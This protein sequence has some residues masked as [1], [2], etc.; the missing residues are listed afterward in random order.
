MTDAH[1]IA[2]GL[3]ELD[4]YLAAIGTCGDGGC[5]VLKPKGMHTNGGCRCSRS[6]FTMQRL[7]YGHRRFVDRVRA[8]LG[9]AEVMDIPD[10]WITHDG[11]PCPVRGPAVI[12]VVIRGGLRGWVTPDAIGWEHIG[13]IP[14]SD[15]IAYKPEEP[16]P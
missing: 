16:Q 4:E 12:E 14:M 9:R 15:I 1:E 13:R 2:R 5:I 11:G 6:A 10:G 8:I 7:A 3:A